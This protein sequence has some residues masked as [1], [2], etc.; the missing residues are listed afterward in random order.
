ML[1]RFGRRSARTSALVLAIAIASVP[2]AERPAA[3]DESYRRPP[4]PIADILE[5]PAFPDAFVS[6]ARD[7]A[8]LATPLRFP[9]IRDLARPHLRADGIDL[10]PLANGIRNAPA[11]V[12]FET[13]RIAT[14]AT[15]AID[16]PAGTRASAPV[17]KPDGTAF[18][19]ADQT[20]HGTQLDLVT[21]ATGAVRAYE[22]VRLNALFG[23]AISWLPNGDGLLVHTIDAARAA[24]PPAPHDAP[25]VRESRGGGHGAGAPGADAEHANEAERVAYYARGSYATL[26]ARTGTLGTL[27]AAGIA[28]GAA[29]SPD[30]A[31][32]AFRRYAEPLADGGSL[33]DA[34]HATVVVNRNGRT[35]ATIANVGSRS[36]SAAWQ[37]NAKA[38]LVWIDARPA[39]GDAVYSLAVGRGNAPRAVLGTQERL[40]S[41]AFLDGTSTALFRDYDRRTRVS[42]TLE[43]DVDA[44]A[45]PHVLGAVTDGDAFD[46]P[47]LPLDRVGRGD[48]VVARDGDAIFLAGD[49]Y[50]TAG[51]RPFV[52]RVDLTTH[53][54]R[55]LFSSAL[56]PLETVVAML[57]DRGTSFLVRRQSPATPPDLF[58]RDIAGHV[59]Q[60]THFVDPAPALR[61][62]RPRVVTYK[63]ADGV[64][65]S[66]TLYLPPGARAGTPLPTLLW[67]YPFEFDD[68]AA[69]SQN[70]NFIQDFDEPR[71]AAAHLAAF[72]GYAVLDRVSMPIVVPHGSTASDTL[73]AQLTMDA[74]AAIDEAVALGV[75]D[76]SRVA[77]G[78]HSYGAFMAATLLA[79]TSLFR[80]GIARSGA[81]NRSL[82]PFGFQNEARTF[83]DAPDVYAKLSPFA[84][85]NR[86]TSPLLLIAGTDDDNPATPPLQSERMY[87]AIRGTGGTARLV[88]LPNESHTYV[89]REGVET[90]EAETIDWLDRY[91]G[92]RAR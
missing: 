20:A 29:I 2:F 45:P 64:S 10:D 34:P 32:V 76:R 57:D 83:W 9:P 12:A 24:L 33:Q 31:Y 8:L 21:T 48:S 65:C 41:I 54:K 74:R 61:T 84:F 1:L 38:T 50:T 43:F 3:S 58:V 81:Y 86:I 6:P 15:L 18:A 68:P 25:I 90:A 55:R 60:L 19:F 72:A 26:D 7:V 52:D 51:I 35:V 69:A 59:R 22:N 91:V 4:A 17:W 11:Y 47:G 67:A 63:R 30:G 82:T 42:R 66:F 77:V 89:S 80:A 78:G 49:G 56:D 36:T 39:A 46:D 40:D 37:P 70:A 75:T 28:A 13:V 79:H 23:D 92:N 27:V 16:L 85:A 73:V 44:P 14:G 88:L 62:L 53:V 71:G 5:A 87:D